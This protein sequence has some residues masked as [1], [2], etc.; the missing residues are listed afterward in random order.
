MFGTV[1]AIIKLASCAA[2]RKL[3]NNASVQI[4]FALERH[5]VPKSCLREANAT[6]HLGRIC[7][8][9]RVSVAYANRMHPRATTMHSR[10]GWHLRATKRCTSPRGTAYVSRRITALHFAANRR[11]STHYVLL[12][13]RMCCAPLWQKHARQVSHW[14]K[15]YF[16]P[17]REALIGNSNKYFLPVYMC[18]HYLFLSCADYYFQHGRKNITIDFLLF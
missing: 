11:I 10:G 12:T 13:G 2:A 16:S 14:E 8:I 5:N 7:A 15:K 9:V 1:V 17:L 18:T 4:A 6:H 3:T